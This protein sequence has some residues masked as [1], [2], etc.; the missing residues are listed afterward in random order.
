MA[1]C[2]SELC[3]IKCCNESAPCHRYLANNAL[4]M[5]RTDR[6]PLTKRT[7]PMQSRTILKQIDLRGD[8]YQKTESNGVAFDKDCLGGP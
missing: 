3:V 5:S 1:V 8:N 6:Q 7:S 4:A 2:R